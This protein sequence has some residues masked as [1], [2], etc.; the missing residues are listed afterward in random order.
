MATDCLSRD[1]ALLQFHYKSTQT[2][3]FQQRLYRIAHIY[4]LGSQVK[5]GVAYTRHL[6]LAIL[7]QLAD[8]QND[9]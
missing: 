2:R 3:T 8:V 4:V 7:D 1:V 9:Y 5:A 6:S